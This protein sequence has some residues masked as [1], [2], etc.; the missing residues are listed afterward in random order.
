MDLMAVDEHYARQYLDAVEFATTDERTA[1]HTMYGGESLPEI[2]SMNGSEREASILIS[3]LLS[4]NGPSFLARFF[5]FNGTAYK[6]I[7]TAANSLKDDPSIDTVRL[8]MNTPGGYVDGMDQAYYALKELA[9]SKKV[10]AENHGMIASAGYYLAVAATEIIAITR[11]AISGSIGVKIAKVDYSDSDA[12]NG[13]KTIT[14][15]SR[16]AP[17]KEPDPATAQGKDVIQREID[18]AERVFIRTIALGRGKTDQDV[19]DNFGKG[20]MLIAQDPDPDQPSALS[21][22]MIDRVVKAIDDNITEVGIESPEATTADG[23]TT[24]IEVSIMDLEKLK[25]EHPDAYRAAVAVG[26]TQGVT[27]ERERVDAH[28]TLGE[29]SGDVEYAM[30]CIKDGA[31]VGASVQAKHFA[32]SMKK[33]AIANRADDTPGDLDTDDV[34]GGGSDDHEA[35]LAKAVANKLGVEA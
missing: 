27:Q 13:I 4:V 24:T 26:V 2:V 16:N 17:D 29:A 28:L 7:I 20:A 10:I 19:I 22:G 1:A 14:I 30:T 23:G 12:R 33:Q 15:I 5:G 35:E 8:V 34:D 21:A 6:D 31:D 11:L 9:A 18:A 25:A 3:G 32:A